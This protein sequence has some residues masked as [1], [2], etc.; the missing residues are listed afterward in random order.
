MN[1]CK[2]KDN[3]WLGQEWDKIEVCLLFAKRVV[4]DA[5]EPWHQRKEHIITCNS[6]S[7]SVIEEEYRSL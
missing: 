1:L 4:W 3:F 5:D 6:N 2:D 7:I